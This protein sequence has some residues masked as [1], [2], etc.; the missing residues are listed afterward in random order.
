[1][2]IQVKDLKKELPK[3]WKTCRDLSLDNIIGDIKN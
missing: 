1:M 2:L 3:E